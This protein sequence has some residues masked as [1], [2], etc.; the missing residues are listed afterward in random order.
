MARSPLP[1]IAGYAIERELGSGAMARVYLAVQE[2]LNRRVALKM[3]KPGTQEFQERFLREGRAVARLKHHNII[4]VHDVGSAQDCYFM[5]IEYAEGG[6]LEARIRQGLSVEQALTIL[7]Q[8]AAGLDHAHQQGL[9]HRDI[10]PANILFR[11]DGEAAVSDF[12]IAKDQQ[13]NQQLT[14]SGWVLGTPSYMSPEQVLGQAV[15]NRSDLYS[16]GVLF[17]EM[18]TGNKPYHA[19]ETV[20]LMAMHVNEPIPRLPSELIRFQAV[21]DRLM[22]KAPGERFSTAGELL[23]ELKKLEAPDQNGT[24][25]LAVAG[26]RNKE[27]QVRVEADSK[28]GAGYALLI[29]EGLAVPEDAMFA[30]QSGAHHLSED[31]WQTGECFFNPL[32]LENLSAWSCRVV[33]G[34]HVVRHMENANYRLKIYAPSW[35]EPQQRALSWRDIPPPPLASASRKRK[36]GRMG[37]AAAATAPAEPP[38]DEVVAVAPPEPAAPPPAPIPTLDEQP[39]VVAQTPPATPAPIAAPATD[40][41]PAIATPQAAS[42]RSSNTLLL[43]VLVGALA[44][45]AG[46]YWWWSQSAAP[47]PS[48]A[49]KPASAAS[50][51]AKPPAPALSLQATRQQLQSGMDAAQAYQQAQQAAAQADGEQSALLLYQYAAEHGHAAAMLKMGEIYDPTRNEPTPLPRRRAD[52]AH[53]WYSKAQAAGDPEAAVRLQGLRTWAEQEAGRGNA[54]AQQLLEDWH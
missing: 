27:W 35:N 20:A 25:P 12:G 10:K 39:T 40:P 43:V 38:L 17:Y 22:A 13:Q 41:S 34:P 3:M 16:L 33:F 26:M 44:A 30:I 36:R 15:D 5:V 8:I 53:D 32:L 46:G 28:R 37:E 11:T 23:A 7:K 45:A 52:K 18:L 49:T 19:L 29:I 21:L 31:G 54:E 6:T 14:Q 1:E 51:S 50:S 24:I 4:P 2:T 9:V 42:A 47:E 48:A